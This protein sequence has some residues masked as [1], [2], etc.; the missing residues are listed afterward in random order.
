MQR[1]RSIILRTNELLDTEVRFQH[2]DGVAFIVPAEQV[3]KIAWALSK[4]E[5]ASQKCPEPKM[6][7]RVPKARN[8]KTS[9]CGLVIARVILGTLELGQRHWTDINRR[10]ARS[11]AMHLSHDEMLT[12]TGIVEPDSTQRL[13]SINY[14][15][16]ADVCL[17][18]LSADQ[19]WKLI[20]E[21]AI[22]VGFAI[23][24]EGVW[25]INPRWGD[26]QGKS[27]CLQYPP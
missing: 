18:E 23:R 4:R 16:Q 8:L 24:I 15:A 14:I 13:N 26:R 10:V 20:K 9:L 25:P 1:K 2:E 3:F 6:G 17:R 21:L 19:S 11:A 7:V 27:I 5:S 12:F 22:R